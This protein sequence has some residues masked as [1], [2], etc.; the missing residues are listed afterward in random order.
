MKYKNNFNSLVDNAYD[1]LFEETCEYIS[2]FV[3]NDKWG[4]ELHNLHGEI[5]YN[6][7]VELYESFTSKPNV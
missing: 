1:L 6:L 3:G 5:M 4:E 2:D 7:I